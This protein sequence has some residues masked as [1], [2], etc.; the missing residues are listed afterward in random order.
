VISDWLFSDT[1]V[2]H[3]SALKKF[4]ASMWAYFRYAATERALAT[5]RKIRQRTIRLE[6]DMLENDMLENAM[7]ETVLDRSLLAP[8]I[9]PTLRMVADA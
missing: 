3:G 9:G 6:N 8:A 2:A 1:L 5:V 7:V 4:W